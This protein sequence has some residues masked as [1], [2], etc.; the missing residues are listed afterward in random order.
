MNK[1]FK[2]IGAAIGECAATIGPEKAPDIIKEKLGLQD[3]WQATIY[4][5]AKQKPPTIEEISNFFSQLAD[6]TED[7]LT[8]GEKFI[9]FGG[10][11]SCAIGTWSGVAKIHDEFGLIWIDAHMD[12]HTHDTTLSGNVH[13]MPVASLLG[14]GA[15]ELKTIALARPKI[16]AENI[17]L[18]G[19]RSYEAE[20]KELLDSLGVK[21]FLM[22]EVKQIGFK[23]CMDYALNHFASKNMKYGISLDVDGLDPAYITATGT[24]VEDGIDLEQLCT[25]FA[26]IKL[27]DLIGVEIV[28]YNPELDDNNHK[29]LATIK[30]ILQ[31]IPNTM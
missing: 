13:G 3:N 27:N 22:D 2:Y 23:A 21:V 7:V 26:K 24:M 10:D 6:V 16:K 14:V 20:E 4:C 9:T 1:N 31:A 8:K 28:E 19:I 11:H 17:V 15:D 25:E 18:I 5:N 29:D 12:A 30:R